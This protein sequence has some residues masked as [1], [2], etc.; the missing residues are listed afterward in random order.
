MNMMNVQD[1]RDPGGRPL[2]ALHDDSEF[3]ETRSPN[4]A[5]EGYF[6]TKPT[7]GV[8]WFRNLP[9]AAKVNTIFAGFAVFGVAMLI[10]LAYGMNEV[11]NRYHVSDAIERTITETAEFKATFGELRYT[12]A[13]LLAEQENDLRDR[14]I[15]AKT[16]AVNQLQDIESV[17]SERAPQMAPRVEQLRQDLD[18]YSAAFDRAIA[19]TDRNSRSSRASELVVEVGN[20]G[21]AVFASAESLVDELTSHT[22]TMREVGIDYFLSV[23]SIVGLLAALTG[24]ILFSGFGILSR[25]LVT[26][27]AEVRTGMTKLAN[28][29]QD[30]EINGT[31]RQ[32]EIGDMLRALVMFKRAGRQLESLA[33]ERADHAEKELRQ[34]QDLAREREEAEQRR[35]A[36]ISNVASSFERTVG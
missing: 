3:A 21:E 16:E 17:L 36:L 33:R 35:A 15:A 34:Q 27:I 13:R 29:E 30:F 10:V 20:S 18:A 25:D 11:W 12:S 5:D 8:T 6:R 32:D 28:G 9:I 4:A 26:K 22:D 14:R 1:H 23:L 31:E 2:N 19:E 7:F 24:V